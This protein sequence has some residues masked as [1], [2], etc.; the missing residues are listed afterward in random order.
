MDIQLIHFLTTDKLRL[1]GLLYEP[2]VKTNKAAMYLHGNGTASIFYKPGM[3]TLGK[4]LTDNGIAFFPFNNRGAHLIKSLKR[5]TEDKEERVMSGTAYEL[6][7]ECIID[8]DA[9]IAELKTRGYDE[10]YLIGESTGANKIVVYNYYKQ[11]NDV[12]KYILLSGGDDTGL[13]YKE[14]GNDRFMEIL[15]IS[16]KKIDAGLGT[17]L[18]DRNLY[19]GMP[20]SYQSMYDTLNPDGDYNIFPFNEV[21]NKLQLS[22]KELLV[23]YKSI[24]KPTL[25]IYGSEDEFCYGKVQEC[26]DILKKNTVKPELFQYEIIEG[27]DHGFH[28][29]EEEL[30]VFIVNFL[31]K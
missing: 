25:V 13:Y 16:K 21:M 12:T 27:A 6:I 30:F 23:E 19:S 4:K 7:K 22:S 28:G 20:M 10:F 5:E 17:E 24:D 31:T 3:N 1:P 11:Q 29:Q 9:V 14:L 26:V 15:K 18:L 2:K 8:I